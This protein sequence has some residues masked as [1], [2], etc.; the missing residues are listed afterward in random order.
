MKCFLSCLL[1][2]LLL[3]S[4]SENKSFDRSN[5]RA[6]LE[7]SQA[8]PEPVVLDIVDDRSLQELLCQ[9]GPSVISTYGSQDFSEQFSLVCSEGDTNS[10]FDNLIR[11]SYQ[12]EGTPE[13]HIAKFSTTENFVTRLAFAYA[14]KVPL[15]D[16][17]SFAD[18][19]VHDIFAAGIEANDS[20]LTIDVSSRESFP[21]RRS[22]E[23]VQ[24]NYDLSKARGAGI[25]DV[26]QSE[27][28]TYILVE[29]NRDIT[30]STEHLLNRDHEYYH[31]AKGLTVG[32]RADLGYSYLIFITD[33]IIINRIDPNRLSETLIS[34]NEEVAVML[35]DYLQTYQGD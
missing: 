29:D 6:D 4:C 19:Q 17:S 22:V 32:I 12:G 30:V 24:L 10:F 18:A 5:R 7:V 15:D 16:P 11:D 25:H 20:K 8:S 31:Q 23:K 3:W 34:L 26:R 21:G 2:G 28:N 35:Y 9:E 14:I 13:I 33:L 1:V 27:F